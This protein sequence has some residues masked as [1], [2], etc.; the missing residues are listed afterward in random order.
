[1]GKV[2]KHDFFEIHVFTKD[3]TPPHFH[4]YFP[5]KS[6]TAGSFK[7]LLKDES[8]ELEIIELINVGQK[9]LAKLEKFLTKERIKILIAEWEGF[10]GEI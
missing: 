4:V 8:E 3:H 9:D 5:K 6:N 1:M 7:V 2:F 10:H